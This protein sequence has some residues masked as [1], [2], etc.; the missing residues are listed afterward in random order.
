MKMKNR[1]FIFTG[2]VLLVA[3]GL[4][5]VDSGTE[6]MAE[7]GDTSGALAVIEAFHSAL[8]SKDSVGAMGLLA[9]DVLVQ[10]GGHI[11]T[12]DE[13]LGHHLGADMEFASQ[14]PGERE[15]LRSVREGDVAWVASK[16]QVEGEFNGRP[17]LAA[18][19]ELMVLSKANGVWKIRLIHWSSYNK[20]P[21]G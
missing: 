12:R 19:A 16:S 20:K 13:Y 4:F 2:V 14:V 21:G 17:V 6:S 8:A 9:D 15:V 18:G 3:G 7:G 5:I 1:L 10:E 11:E